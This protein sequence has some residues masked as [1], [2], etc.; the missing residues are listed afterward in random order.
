MSR[1]GK[2]VVWKYV[3]CSKEGAKNAP[4]GDECKRRAISKRV[5][6]MVRVVFKFA[7][8]DGYAMSK[9]IE[10]HTHTLVPEAYK[11]FM[12]MN[13]TLDYGH[14]KFILNYA[15]A[16]V[17]AMGSYKVLKTIADSY[18]KIGCTSNQVKNFSRDLKTY[19]LGTDAQ[20]LID[21]LFKK[22]ELCSA[23]FFEFETDGQDHLKSLFWADPIARRNYCSYC[24]VISFDTTYNTNKYTM[25]FA[26]F[27]GKDNHG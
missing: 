21:N 7:T 19:A 26:P 6:C 15:K 5:Y 18:S 14:Q 10:Q 9:F 3:Y 23:F 11:H 2:C 20:M 27:T 24:D 16:N 1:D 4:I 25:I 22:R 17:G 12:K 13:T 8:S